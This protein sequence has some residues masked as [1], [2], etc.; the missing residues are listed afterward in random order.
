MAWRP[1]ALQSLQWARR[2]LGLGT[3]TG[4]GMLQSKIVSITWSGA[5][6][7]LVALQGIWQHHTPFT[8][9][10][11]AFYLLKEKILSFGSYIH[12]VHS[13]HNTSLRFAK[14][15][16][17]DLE[18]ER[19]IFLQILYFWAWLKFRSQH[20][21]YIRSLMALPMLEP[22]NSGLATHSFCK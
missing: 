6:C 13:N 8:S 3:R 22:P 4:R 21:H 2:M 9:I 7:E 15:H 10:F 11:F 16:V 17:F 19:R 1:S 12:F 20:F 5:N 14:K 18:Q